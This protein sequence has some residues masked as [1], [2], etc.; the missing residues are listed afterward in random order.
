MIER[1][2]GLAD[3]WPSRNKLIADLIPPGSSVLDLG[4][5]AQG[6]RSMLDP[7][8]PYTPAD[9]YQRTPDTL[10]FNM[11]TGAWPAGHWDIV[12]MSGVLEY[13]PDP[14]KVFHRLRS[15]A[16]TAIVTYA[17]RGLRRRRH[18]TLSQVA[19]IEAISAAGWQAEGVGSWNT[20]HSING[21]QTIWRLT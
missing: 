3:W 11:T 7:S 20:R 10:I 14:I 12:V 5:G 4:A 19:F 8:C 21:D 18:R 16:D 2:I 17:H 15:L 6:L 13:A 9:L 1:W